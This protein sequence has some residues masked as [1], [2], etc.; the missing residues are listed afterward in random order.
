MGTPCSGIAACS[1]CRAAAASPAPSGR[2][3]LQPQPCDTHL[4]SPTKLAGPAGKIDALAGTINQAAEQRMKDA[5]L[6]AFN[7]AVQAIQ[8]AVSWMVW[9]G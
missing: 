8:A 7:E 2:P 9:M 4:T 3:Y 1:C 5:D 6:V